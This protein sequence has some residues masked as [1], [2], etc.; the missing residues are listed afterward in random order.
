MSVCQKQRS[1]LK[2]NVVLKLNC[3]FQE[4]LSTQD[5]GTLFRRNSPATKVRGF[6]LS[7]SRDNRALTPRFT[8]HHCIHARG[9]LVLLG[10]NT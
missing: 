9:S 4:V 1:M 7:I 5:E 6:V 10:R 3:C 2:S 8:A